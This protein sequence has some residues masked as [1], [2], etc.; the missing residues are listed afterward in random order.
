MKIEFG[1][2][3]RTRYPLDGFILKNS[4]EQV[5]IAYRISRE[6]GITSSF[7]NKI[8]QIEYSGQIVVYG[9]YKFAKNDVIKLHNGA[10]LQVDAWTPVYWS[11]NIQVRHLLKPRVK[12]IL[13]DLK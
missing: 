2:L 11:R 13:V 9:D 12:E 5:P 3:D 7:I 4:G 8:E 10:M 6:V 1:R